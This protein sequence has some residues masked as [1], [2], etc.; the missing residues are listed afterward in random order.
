MPSESST[1]ETM[2]GVGVLLEDR[3]AARSA[4]RVVGDGVARIAAEEDRAARPAFPSDAV[5]LLDGC[6]GPT[7]QAGMKRWMAWL[8]LSWNVAFRRPGKMSAWSATGPV[9]V[10]AALA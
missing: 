8:A 7:G 5:Q 3:Q 4:S 6:G 10:L 2:N 9:T 1:Y